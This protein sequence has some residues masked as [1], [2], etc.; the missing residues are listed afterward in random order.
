MQ[1]E[2]FSGL[3]AKQAKLPKACSDS[4]DNDLVEYMRPKNP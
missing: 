2:H 3:I 1:Q 4:F